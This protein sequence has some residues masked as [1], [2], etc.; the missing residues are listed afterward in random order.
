[1]L[2]GGQAAP[3]AVETPKSNAAPAP[4]AAP[5]PMAVAS[6]DA[7]VLEFTRKLKELKPG[8]PEG[9]V[10]LAK[11]CENNRQ[12]QMA[13]RIYRSAMEI[14]PDHAEAYEGLLSLSLKI[15]QPRST[16]LETA[17]QKELGPRFTQHH[18]A[19]FTIIHDTDEA[20]AKSRASM[21]ENALMVF[22]Q[23]FSQ[24]GFRPIPLTERLVCVMF[25]DHADYKAYAMRIDGID[26]AWASGYYSPRSNR[27]AFFNN[28]TSPEMKNIQTQ[29]AQQQTLI[30]QLGIE[31]RQA[32][33][34]GQRSR[35]AA[36]RKRRDA[37]DRQLFVLKRRF[38]SLVG[39]NNVS[40]TY[41]EV[42]H[43][44][45]F[46]SGIQARNA[47]YPFW[48]SEG[49]ATNFETTSPALEFGPTAVNATRRAVINKAFT[50]KA[51]TPIESLIASSKASDDDAEERSLMYAQSWALFQYL[52]RNR[53]EDLKAYMKK[54]EGF[55]GVGVDDAMQKK[56]FIDSFGPVEEIERRLLDFLKTGKSGRG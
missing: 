13:M 35:A 3:P 43:Q 21:L 33:S 44:L 12:F 27:I 50:E 23:R 26:I 22:Y 34:G 24:A 10:A 11:W 25:K 18:S 56:F 48:L 8:D 42:A 45:A 38:D 30:S 49:I 28:D 55:K 40:K 54:L 19:N 2:L 37:E 7:I 5:M 29:I 14:K 41:H 15:E 36:I 39:L 52:F 46:N 53:Q 32:A 16:P 31:E 6:T 1:M 20:W 51:W 4:M 17:L 47:Q 9:R